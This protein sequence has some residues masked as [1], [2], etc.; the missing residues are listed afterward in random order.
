M[1]V[2][3]RSIDSLVPYAKNA[4]THSNAQVR[5]LKESIRTFGF[6]NPALINREGMII[7]GH[8]RVRAAKLLGMTTVPT[9]CLE[10]LTAD[11]VRAY[12]IADNRLAED[13][14]WDR[15][16]LAIELQYLTTIDTEFDVTITG[17]EIPEIDLIVKPEPAEEDDILQ[18]GDQGSQISQPGE[19]KLSWWQL[20]KLVKEAKEARAANA[21]SGIRELKFVEQRKLNGYQAY[22]MRLVRC[23]IENRQIASSERMFM[24]SHIRLRWV[25]TV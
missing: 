12:V 16:L 6:V 14:G 23:S 3:Y 18:P 1:K 25:P 7:A 21:F 17:F 22:V 10:S 20:H 2:S 9:I 24:Y 15:S 5:K 8:G 11:Q 4:R 13:A 19:W